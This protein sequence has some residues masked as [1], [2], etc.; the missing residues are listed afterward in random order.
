MTKIRQCDACD[1]VFDI[2]RTPLTPPAVQAQ[3]AYH[4]ERANHYL[5]TFESVQDKSTAG[6]R[7]GPGELG[8]L[9]NGLLEVLGAIPYEKRIE[10]E[11]REKEDEE[12][13][14]RR[15]NQR[16]SRVLRI[17]GMENRVK[18]TRVLQIR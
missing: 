4:I 5:K 10:L 15:V 1:N 7:T 18:A 12:T 6:I 16:A 2:I 13:R 9:L 11:R 3:F 17:N 14:Q 8:R